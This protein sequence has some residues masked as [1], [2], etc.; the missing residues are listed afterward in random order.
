MWSL[1]NIFALFLPVLPIC[2]CPSLHIL[3]QLSSPTCTN[4][5]NERDGASSDWSL[6]PRDYALQAAREGIFLIKVFTLRKVSDDRLMKNVL[7]I[8]QHAETYRL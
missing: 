7:F 5:I 1:R 6:L 4:P 8:I 2:L 3:A